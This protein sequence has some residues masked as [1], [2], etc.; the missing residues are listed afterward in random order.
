[1][2]LVVGILVVATITYTSCTDSH[3]DVANGILATGG[4]V[5]LRRRESSID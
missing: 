3:V 2:T 4:G 1:M 5:E